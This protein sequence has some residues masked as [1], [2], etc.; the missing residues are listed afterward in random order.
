[1]A[2]ILKTA[3]K[4]SS[5]ERSSE[6]SWYR[7]T[8][9]LQCLRASLYMRHLRL[10]I[11]QVA[12]A[13][14]LLPNNQSRVRHSYPPG[15]HQYE[16][17]RIEPVVEYLTAEHMLPHPLATYSLPSEQPSDS[18]FRLPSKPHTPYPSTNHAPTAAHRNH[19]SRTPHA[20]HPAA[21]PPSQA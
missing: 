3:C 15:T 19:A 2:S 7:R 4:G 1:M 11:D 5:L 12:I 9:D 21:Y 14:M 8:P 17:A 13:V 10:R 16:P 6:Y 20:Q 18:P